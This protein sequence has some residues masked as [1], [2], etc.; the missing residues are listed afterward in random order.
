VEKLDC[1]QLFA[2]TTPLL[3]SGTVFCVNVVAP[4]TGKAVTGL[5]PAVV[6]GCAQLLA[7]NSWT[8]TYKNRIRIPRMSVKILHS[9]MG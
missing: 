8:I 2:G 4:Q 9:V 6:H 7:A 5:C 3:Q 1:G